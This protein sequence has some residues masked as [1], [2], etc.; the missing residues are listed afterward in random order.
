MLMSDDNATATRT[1]VK[2]IVG[3]MGR[4]DLSNGNGPN[5]SVA[6]NSRE[7]TAKFEASR[8]ARTVDADNAAVSGNVEG[9]LSTRARGGYEVGIER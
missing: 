7:N 5:H 4:S 2:A 8:E 6:N 3:L 9:S 1:S